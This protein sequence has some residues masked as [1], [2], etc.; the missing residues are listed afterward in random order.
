MKVCSLPAHPTVSASS[1]V[2]SRLTRRRPDT[3]DGVERLRA[4]EPLLLRH[5]EEQLER[6]VRD[7]R[8]LDDGHRRRDADAVVRAERRAVGAHPVAVDDGRRSAPRAD[9]TGCPDPAR[10][11]C[12]GAPG[13]RPSARSR[14]RRTRERERR[15]CPPRRRW[16]RT[17]ALRRP[18]EHVRTRRLLRLRRPRDPRQL[19]EALPD[20][21]AARARRAV[22]G[23]RRS[24]SAAPTHEQTRS[25]ARAAR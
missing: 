8:V 6:A 5:G 14:G 20:E 18:G 15:R 24:V 7:L 1:L 11:P 19:E 4:V 12:P 25:R 22:L 17:I 16:S 9:R 13:G 3:S 21:R 2:P 23:H 10:T